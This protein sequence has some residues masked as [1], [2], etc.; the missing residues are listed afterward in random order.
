MEGLGAIC[1]KT[2]AIL[3]VVLRACVQTLASVIVSGLI[4]ACSTSRVQDKTTDAANDETIA[5]PN[6]SIAV[7]LSETAQKKLQGYA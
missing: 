5:V 1:G 2:G 3:L 6:F 4:V 7:K